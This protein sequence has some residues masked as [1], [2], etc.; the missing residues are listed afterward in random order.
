MSKLPFILIFLLTSLMTSCG[1][2]VQKITN[3]DL[4]KI[5]TIKTN[6]LSKEYVSDNR[7]I[8]INI[9][10]LNK[11]INDRSKNKY[12]TPELAKAKAAT[13]RFYK[14]VSLKDGHYVV[15]TKSA[16]ELNISDDLF[17]L[18]SNNIKDM[19]K[20]V[21]SLKAKNVDMKLS[22]VTPDYLNS[23]LN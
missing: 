1:K 11:E 17:L 19:N 3:A 5:A 6:N 20:S 4:E 2:P 21:D 10:Q 13:Y 18:F 16:K 23:L 8:E 14:N 7:F 22:P 15:D 12:Q 9:D